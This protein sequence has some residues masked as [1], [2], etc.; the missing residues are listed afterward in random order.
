MSMKWK[1]FNLKMESESGERINNG[2][3]RIKW[4]SFEDEDT[5]AFQTKISKLNNVLEIHTCSEVL[6]S[7]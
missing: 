1:D 4:L 6:N 2:R 7:F 3:S 5:C